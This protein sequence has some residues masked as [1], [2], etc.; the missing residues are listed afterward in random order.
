MATKSTRLIA[1]L[2]DPDTKRLL[3]RGGQFVSVEDFP[4]YAPERQEDIVPN[5][6]T[7]AVDDPDEVEPEPGPEIK[8]LN[9]KE[10]WC[11]LGRCYP[12]GKTC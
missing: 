11:Y 4:K 8:C 6:R 7:H 10:H 2:Y 1:V 3:G 5:Q 12:T 9:G